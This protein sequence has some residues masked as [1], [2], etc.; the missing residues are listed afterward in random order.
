MTFLKG[1]GEEISIIIVITINV[2]NDNNNN[3]NDHD[4]NNL[5]IYEPFSGFSRPDS[6]ILNV[7]GC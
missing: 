4:Y 3:I 1:G 7:S 6:C 5:I 2:I